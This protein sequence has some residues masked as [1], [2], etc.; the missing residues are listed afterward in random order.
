MKTK[1]SHF[2]QDPTVDSTELD[3]IEFDTKINNGPKDD[4]IEIVGGR[5]KKNANHFLIKGKLDSLTGIELE[6]LHAVHTF[7]SVKIVLDMYRKVFK[8]IDV[9]AIDLN[10][11]D[12][13]NLFKKW[14]NKRLRVFLVRFKK[15]GARYT[16]RSNKIDFGF[17]DNIYTCQSFDIVAHETAHSVF[18]AI[19]NPHDRKRFEDAPEIAEGFADLAIIFGLLT[20]E[21]ICRLVVNQTERDIRSYKNFVPRIGEQYALV[22]KEYKADYIR[23]LAD[24]KKG[25]ITIAENPKIHTKSL[26]FTGGIYELIMRLFNNKKEKIIESGNYGEQEKLNIALAKELQNIAWFIT[27]VTVSAFYK[28]RLE[29]KLTFK[30]LGTEM[31][32]I[33]SNEDDKSAHTFYSVFEEF[34]CFTLKN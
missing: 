18:E 21:K 2:P 24:I 7:A 23:N 15:I 3:V 10:D 1:M 13:F 34:D 25:A 20:Q 19:R 12:E 5:A 28:N 33:I 29:G 8:E 22:S 4:L 17:L 14:G 11:K 9:D 16:S 27:K 30:L 26:L 6:V 32:R 31:G